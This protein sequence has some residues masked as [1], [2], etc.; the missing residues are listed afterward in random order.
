[1][2]RKLRPQTRKTQTL[3]VSRKLRPEKLKPPGCRETSDLKNTDPLGVSKTQFC[4]RTKIKRHAKEAVTLAT[5]YDLLGSFY[6]F[7]NQ[8]YYWVITL[9]EFLVINPPELKYKQKRIID[10]EGDV[11]NVCC[12]ESIPCFLEINTSSFYSLFV[13]FSVMYF[14]AKFRF[15]MRSSMP[16]KCMK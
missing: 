12:K 13:K 8:I 3:W 7:C 4:N 10:S 2:S 1:M 6:L 5:G 16:V 14:R 11:R 9:G 15:F